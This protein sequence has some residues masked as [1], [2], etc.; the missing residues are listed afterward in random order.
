M[1]AANLVVVRRGLP[2]E[3]RQV[4]DL[5]QQR[6]LVE[7]RLERIGASRHRPARIPSAMPFRGDKTARLSRQRHHAAVVLLNDVR[8]NGLV[9]QID[10]KRLAGGLL[11][12][13]LHVVGQHVGDVA[14]DALLLAVHVE[15]RIDRL[16]LARH[17]DPARE[18]RPRA[19][20]V[21][22]VPLAEEARAVTACWSSR[23]NVGSWWLLRA[24]LSTMPW[25]RAY[26]PVRKL[27]RLGEQSGVV[28]NALRKRAPSR[29]RR[30]MLGV[31]TK[32]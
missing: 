1:A 30:S 2:S 13:L 7:R 19:V 11:D 29:A 25:V 9:S 3:R 18:S 16:T 27:A 10:E 31:S 5:A 24:V 28:A 22:H 4:V 12:E 20:V 17:R 8:V 14:L 6:G 21:A 32:G 26:W 15:Q 23:G